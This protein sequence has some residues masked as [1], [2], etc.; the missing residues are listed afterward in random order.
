ML[1][2]TVMLDLPEDQHR[3]IN[4]HSKSWSNIK[5]EISLLFYNGFWNTYYWW[6]FNGLSFTIYIHFKLICIYPQTFGDI[7][8]I[9]VG[10]LAQ[11]PPVHGEYQICLS[12]VCWHLFYPFFINQ[13]QRY[14]ANT[15]VYQM[16]EEI[17][18]GNI[19][20]ETWNRCYK[21]QILINRNIH[22]FL[23]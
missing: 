7:N 21:G 20:D 9:V 4:Y 13:P 19:S 16:L 8:V 11:L 3:V 10:D 14:Q 6:N 17:R 23:S 22:Y 18:F 1:P 2:K 12:F 15:H 5:K